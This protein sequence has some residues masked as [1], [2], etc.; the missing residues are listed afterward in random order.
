[1]KNFIWIRSIN[2]FKHIGIHFWKYIYKQ[3]SYN[4][5]FPTESYI[6]SKKEA[7]K[8]YFMV[9]KGALHQSNGNEVYNLEKEFASYHSLKN[10]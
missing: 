7:Q 10:S 9:L 3:Q 1:M 8:V 5:A 6:F 4:L 2:L